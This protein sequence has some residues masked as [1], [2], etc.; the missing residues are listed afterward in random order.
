MR[1]SVCCRWFPW[2][3]R[4]RRRRRRLRRPRPRGRPPYPNIPTLFVWR[5]GL[6]LRGST[7]CS[8]Q[9]TEEVRGI[10]G[11]TYGRTDHSLRTHNS[12]A[13]GGSWFI[14]R[15]SLPYRKCRAV[16][17]SICSVHLRPPATHAHAVNLESGKVTTTTTAQR[18]RD[19]N[20]GAAEE[21]R[22]TVGHAR[23]RRRGCRR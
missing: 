15:R 13:V 6:W 9:L 18:I 10:L 14:E 11:R 22:E 23:C 17:Q 3:R 2:L 12:R 19:V 8:D 7:S 21:G 20:E 16:L 1:Q 4:R 5:R